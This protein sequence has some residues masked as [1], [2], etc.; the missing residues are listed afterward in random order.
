MLVMFMSLLC[1][2]VTRGIS[3]GRRLL[4]K[5]ERQHPWAGRGAAA[6][7]VSAV[8]SLNYF[9]FRYAFS[10]LYVRRFFVLFMCISFLDGRGA[11]SGRQNTAAD[12]KIIGWEWNRPLVYLAVLG[13]VGCSW[14]EM[15]DIDILS[16]VPGMLLHSSYQ[17]SRPKSIIGYVCDCRW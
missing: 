11:W 8:G 5:A 1:S 6:M 10:F 9:S 2:A 14:A 12:W 3:C 13:F 16:R 4:A 7:R 17:T 15:C